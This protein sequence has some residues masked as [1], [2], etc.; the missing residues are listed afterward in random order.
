M[1]NL[2]V[3]EVYRIIGSVDEV[4][5]VLRFGI[6]LDDI[7]LLVFKD[8]LKGVIKLFIKVLSV[9]VVV[10]IVIDLGVLIY[11]VVDLFKINKGKLCI[12]VVKF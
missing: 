8:V 5:R 2:K 1:N 3:V 6:V 9:L 12:E 10:G 11:S 7:V 4:V